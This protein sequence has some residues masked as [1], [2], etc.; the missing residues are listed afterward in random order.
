MPDTFRAFVLERQDGGVEAAIRDVSLDELPQGDVLVSVAYSSLN[1]KDGLAVMG[2]GKVVRDYPMV[3][4]IDLAGTVVESKSSKWR[5]G[6]EVI[7]TGWGMGESHWGGF[8]QLARVDGDWLVRL[9]R[10]MTACQAMALGSAGFTAMLALTALEAHNLRPD[11]GQVVVTGAAGGLGSLAVALL[12]RRGYKTV[13]STGRPETHDY[14]RSLGASD[15]LDRNVLAAAPTRPME[16]GRWAGAI[17]TVGGASLAG[18]LRTMKERGS[19]AVCGNAGGVDVQTTVLPFILRGVTLIGIESARVPLRDRQI[20][21]DRLAEEVPM[22]L[23]EHVARVVPLREV[24]SLSEEI[25][26]GRIRG[27]IVVDLHA[28]G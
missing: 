6:D 20:A 1:Y 18:L 3:P 4:G 10:G 12:A 27:R 14:L 26:D 13:A 23:L 28:S 7:L 16:S 15:I 21:W 25:L 8:G 22:G 17:D 24:A 19:I 5:S 11:S 2:R 9:P